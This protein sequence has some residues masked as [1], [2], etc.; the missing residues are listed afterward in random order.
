MNKKIIAVALLLVVAVG[1]V[2]LWSTFSKEKLKGSLTE[3]TA[4]ECQKKIEN[5]ETFIVFIGKSTCDHCQEYDKNLRDYM[6]D[7]GLHMYKV[8]S[9]SKENSDGAFEELYTT[10]FPNLVTVPV[11]YYIVDGEVVDESVGKRDESQITLWIR[12][13]GLELDE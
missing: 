2:L 7:H 5:K 6:K 4:E 3:I 9:D 13:L 1:G 8:T 11:T 12:R 10:Y